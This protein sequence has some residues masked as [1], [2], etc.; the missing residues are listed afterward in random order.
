M[1][2]NY[3]KF[4]I[5]NTKEGRRKDKKKDRVTG[6]KKFRGKAKGGKRRKD[7]RVDK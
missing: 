3:P 6:K 4:Q 7:R 2:D 5:L 1:H